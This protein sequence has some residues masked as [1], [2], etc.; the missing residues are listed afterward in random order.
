[1]AVYED[2]EYFIPLRKSDL[3]ELLCSEPGLTPEEVHDFRQFCTL[4]SATYHFEY[5][6]RLEELKDAYA[7]FDPDADTR[8]L[9][10]L[11]ENEKGTR[12]A[13]LFERFDSLMQRANYEP[14]G[15][16][17]IE[18]ALGVQTPWG[19]DMNI[20]LDVFDRYALYARGDNKGKRTWRRWT[21]LWRA[22][23]IEVDQYQR[24]VLI[25]KLKKHR[26][27]G[28]HVDTNSVFLKVFKD[29]PKPDMEMLL[30][31]AQI[32]MTFLDW[33]LIVLPLLTG[34]GLLGWKFGTDILHHF[35]ALG[36]AALVTIPPLLLYGIVTG[37]VGY[38]YRS[39]HGYQT[40]R[41]KYSLNLAQ[42]LYYQNL[43][44]N[45][46]VL[47]RLIDE[48][49][50][51]EFR[52]ALLAYFFLW[53]HAGRDG[54]TMEHLD[55]SIE[56]YLE[57]KEWKGRKLNI[58]V[59]FEI[60]DAMAKLERM[61]VVEK[62]AVRE[63]GQEVVRYRAQPLAKALEMVDWTWDNYFKYNNPDPEEPPIP[64]VAT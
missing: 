24:L 12:V 30:P 53:R 6:Q 34:F 3:I 1:M 49:E 63:G 31:G 46:G 36:T 39:Y 64:A 35:G 52:E 58:L 7:P 37:T 43:D 59:D 50:E 57:N 18:A 38:G 19:I 62:L 45:A 16:K 48:A 20:D 32:K 2:R 29:I 11:S 8:K 9:E 40:T 17:D 56:E 22:E 13:A 28:R 27:L 21:N 25:F 10:T 4:V 60:D 54:W 26:R 61:R 42:S 14:L 33:A 23:E 41:Q 47:F 15:Q 5:H 51:Q 55:D 44:N